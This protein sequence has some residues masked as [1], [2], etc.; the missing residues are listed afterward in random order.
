MELNNGEKERRGIVRLISDIFSDSRNN[1]A[2]TTLMIIKKKP[3]K[4]YSTIFIEKPEIIDHK[5]KNIN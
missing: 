2:D 4:K 5:K 3:V 1:R